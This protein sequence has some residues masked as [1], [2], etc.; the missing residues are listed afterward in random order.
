MRPRYHITGLPR[1]RERDG[2][3]EMEMGWYVDYVAINILQ[4]TN[5]LD[6]CRL[7]PVSMGT[8]GSHAY[9]SL[10]AGALLT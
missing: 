8:T 10:E 5:V 4:H 2:Q 7:F 1:L 9:I 6:R 3:T